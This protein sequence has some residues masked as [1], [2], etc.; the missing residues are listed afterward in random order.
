MESIRF[1]VVLWGGEGC[2]LVSILIKNIFDVEKVQAVK[3]P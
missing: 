3:R 2:R 1:L